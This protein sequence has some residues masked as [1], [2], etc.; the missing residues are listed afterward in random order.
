MSQIVVPRHAAAGRTAP[1]WVITV[2]AVLAGL[3]VCVAAIFYSPVEP[4]VAWRSAESV[5]VALGRHALP[6]DGLAL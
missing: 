3:A 2:W 4:P 6:D 5:V 1:G